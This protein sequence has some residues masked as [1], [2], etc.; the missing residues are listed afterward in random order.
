MIISTCRE[1]HSHANTNTIAESNGNGRS[2]KVTRSSLDNGV[3]NDNLISRGNWI[4]FFFSILFQFNACASNKCSH[5]FYLYVCMVKCE[6]KL[7]KT[8]LRIN[9]VFV[10]VDNWNF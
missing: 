6:E 2:S 10:V 7:L 3:I 5:Q 9:L 8:L 4:F 1:S